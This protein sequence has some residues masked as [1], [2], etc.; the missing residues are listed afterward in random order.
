MVTFSSFV[1]LSSVGCIIVAIFGTV[2]FTS[3][4]IVGGGTVHVNGYYYGIGPLYFKRNL[5]SVANSIP[6][7]FSLSQMKRDSSKNLNINEVVAVSKR[8][9]HSQWQISTITQVLYEYDYK[10]KEEELRYKDIPPSHGWIAVQGSFPPPT[11]EHYFGNMKYSPSLPVAPTSN[12]HIMLSQPVTM[13]LIALILF[14]GYYLW[15]NRVEVSDVSCSY[16]AI[17]N[18]CEYYRIVTSSF[19]HVDLMHI[20]FNLMALY[21][22][23]NLE[24]FVYGSYMYAWMSINLVVLTIMVMLVLMVGYAKWFSPRQSGD[25]STSYRSNPILLGQSIGYS[26][27]L[28]AWMVDI[29]V[30]MDELCPVIFMPSLCFKTMYIGENKAFPFN[31]GPA[32]LLILTKII[33]PR[34]SF[35]GHLSGILLGLPL[36]WGYLNFLTTP[37]LVGLL[38]LAVVFNE[39]IN[40][41]AVIDDSVMGANSSV[42]GSSEPSPTARLFHFW[43]FFREGWQLLLPCVCIEDETG[44]VETEIRTLVA[45]ALSGVEDS[46]ITSI[47]RI[48]MKIMKMFYILYKIMQVVLICIVLV[49]LMLLFAINAN[50]TQIAFRVSYLAMCVYAVLLVR[51]LL[52]NFYWTKCVRYRRLLREHASGGNGESNGI[53]YQDN[54]EYKQK[55]LHFT[56]RM[57]FIL[58]CMSVCLGL[59]D[60]LNI[61]A[62][63]CSINLVFTVL[64][65]YLSREMTMVAFAIALFLY[66]FLFLLQ[67]MMVLI[68]FFL[69]QTCIYP[70][71]VGVSVLPNFGSGPTQHTTESNQIIS[72][73]RFFHVVN[74]SYILGLQESLLSSG[75]TG[76]L[77]FFM[78]GGGVPSPDPGGTNRS[79]FRDANVV[80]SND[81]D[82]LLYISSGAAFVPADDVE[83]NTYQTPSA[84]E[85]S[86]ITNAGDADASESGGDN[87]T[88][89][90]KSGNSNG[91]C[92]KPVSAAEAAREAALKRYYK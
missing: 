25:T 53:N 3:C 72:F 41:Y 15:N 64:N 76:S 71:I 91:V 11:I 67:G 44:I 85:S 4:V 9:P 80:G 39:G 74:D 61:G 75:V 8:G 51:R 27:V 69:L 40:I 46:A 36:S 70:G 89:T 33:M 20:G 5:D 84:A 66:T 54:S 90:P 88:E 28:F 92:A 30:R 86:N 73:L 2:D 52:L 78:G 62:L 12:M 37:L 49:V 87:S 81:T 18:K 16:D 43:R 6:D 65:E 29:S 58:V 10:D 24:A 1:I 22:F 14:Y 21:Q 57:V 59:C 31:L 68:C 26:C 42:N 35:V 83:M 60:I 55:L 13:L 50:M 77:R 79:D 82:S 38:G 45:S 63:L 23:G 7:Y 47:N 32:A 56:T 17:V 19:A 48:D 34:S